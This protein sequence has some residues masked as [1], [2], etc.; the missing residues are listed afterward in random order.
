MVPEALLRASTISRKPFHESL[1]ASEALPRSCLLSSKAKGL[2]MYQRFLSSTVS[3]SRKPVFCQAISPSVKHDQGINL[4]SCNVDQQSPSPD[5]WMEYCICD[6]VRNL[7]E[8]PF[9]HMLFDS[10]DSSAGVTFQRQRVAESHNSSIEDKWKEVKDSVSKASPDGVIL[11]HHLDDEAME[12]CCLRDGSFQACMKSSNTEGNRSK[13]CSRGTNLWG[14]LVLGKCIAR[15]ACYILKTTSVASSFGT[16]TQFCLTKAKCFGPSWHDQ[17]Q[18]NWLLNT[19][20][21][22]HNN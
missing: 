10:K 5:R 22:D 18:T 17:V 19:E 1:K 20:S 6:I 7:N 9:L 13:K 3:S 16:C 4:A 12:G 21:N 11:V 14:V 15:S 2:R 8:A